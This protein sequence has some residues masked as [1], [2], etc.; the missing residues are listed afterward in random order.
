MHHF[1]H[2]ISMLPST[3]M[4]H[5]PNPTIGYST[6]EA[7]ST[8]IF[9]HYGV[10]AGWSSLILGMAHLCSRVIDVSGE[11]GVQYRI[12]CRQD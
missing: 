10:P 1:S 2:A 5:V 4:T 11:K 3:D 8:S 9:L 7:G 6:H 12:W